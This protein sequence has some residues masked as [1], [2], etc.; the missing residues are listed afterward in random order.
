MRNAVDDPSDG[1]E[2][3]GEELGRPRR[4]KSRN[5]G[6]PDPEPRQVEDDKDGDRHAGQPEQGPQPFVK[7]GRQ[8]LAKWTL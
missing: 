2:P 7:A 6:D 5:R 8:L 3:G 1:E 4:P